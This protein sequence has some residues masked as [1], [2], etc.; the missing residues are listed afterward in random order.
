VAQ[1]IGVRFSTSGVRILKLGKSG[2]DMKIE[3]VAAG[4]PGETFQSFLDNTNISFDDTSVA[5][6]L[7]PGDF[8]ISSLP[9]RDGLDNDEFEE[10]L[11]WEIGRKIISTPADYNYDYFMTD[12]LGY[13]FAGRK[14]LINEMSG[15]YGNALFDVEPV[16]LLNGCESAGELSDGITMMVSIEAGGISSV[17]IENGT[18][19][20]IDSY[21]INEPEILPIMA[22]LDL[23]TISDMD[24]ELVK[25]LAQ[26]VFDTVNRLTSF[27]ENKDN[28]TPD[29]L[30]LTG[31]GVYAGN[32]V[33]MIEEKYGITVA[34]SDPFKDLPNDV[35]DVNPDLGNVHAAF[36]ACFGL[37]MRAMEV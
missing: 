18:P 8:L 24:D 15:D 12:G 33:G 29:K 20:K 28:P 22:G 4:Q 13:V 6:G 9:N 14:K 36:T 21:L 37:A 25:K 23:K 31:T 30:V 27:A 11:R 1:G 2:D 7:G 16:A 19:L 17:I 5:F 34:V 10:Q 35:V 26:H 32:I 3:A